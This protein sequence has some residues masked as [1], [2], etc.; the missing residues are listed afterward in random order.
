N[1]LF[2]VAAGIT[3]MRPCHTRNETSD[4]QSNRAQKTLLHGDDTSPKAEN[5]STILS[6]L[7]ESKSITALPCTRPPP[8][9]RDSPPCT[10][11]RR[12]RWILV[13]HSS[14]IGDSGLGI[15]K[16]PCLKV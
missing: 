12:A 9:S 15:R 16:E 1:R 7:A 5:R 14:G 13:P 2:V 10:P 3:V 6:H 11:Y 4:G 8:Q